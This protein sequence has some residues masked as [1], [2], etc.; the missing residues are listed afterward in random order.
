M[1]Q[2]FLDNLLRNR[3]L[4][5]HTHHETP[6]AHLNDTRYAFSD[7]FRKTL[8]LGGDAVAEI[9]VDNVQH[10]TCRSTGNRVTTKRGAVFARLHQLSGMPVRQTGTDG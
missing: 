4:Q 6:T 9:V 5:H 7:Q 8:T 3:L 10:R 2:G 1:I